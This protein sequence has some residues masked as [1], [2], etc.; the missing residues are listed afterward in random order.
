MKKQTSKRTLAVLPAVLCVLLGPSAYGELLQ[1]RVDVEKA[2][3][4]DPELQSKF[5]L[6]ADAQDP[7]ERDKELGYG[8][9]KAKP[10]TEGTDSPTSP[11]RRKGYGGTGDN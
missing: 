6:T 9:W 5:G 7:S 10:E 8:R 3:G 11:D 1:R 2:S 4:A